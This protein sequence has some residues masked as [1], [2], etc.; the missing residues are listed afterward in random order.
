[1]EIETTTKSK[2]KMNKKNPISNKCGRNFLSKRKFNS[3]GQKSKD[4][5]F[6]QGKVL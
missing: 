3:K 4:V 5:K 6:N 2:N 1:M